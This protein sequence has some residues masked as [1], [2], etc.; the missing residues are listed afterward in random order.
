M[1]ANSLNPKLKIF[2]ALSDSE[3]VAR[4]LQGDHPLFELL[5]R[6]YNRRLFRYSRGVLNDDALAQD[7]VQE[8][9]LN[10][11]KY[12]H[13]FRGPHGFG[14]WLMRITANSAIRIGRKES[15]IKL[16]GSPV[17]PDELSAD[18]SAEPETL[19]IQAE[20]VRSLE[21]AVDRLPRDYRV[22]F[23]L[24]ELEGMSIEETSRTLGVKPA[25]VKSR[26]HRAKSILRKRFKYRLDEFR[27]LAYAFDG[28]RCDS[29]VQQVYLKLTIQFNEEET[30]D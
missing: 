29:I 14:A 20:A 23:I 8:A 15:G 28:V 12:L 18:G 9:Y 30:H 24:R 6:R 3:V 21:N 22:I 11:F 19:T 26:L 25:T 16:V 5:M 17:D 7:A 4:V 13:Q 1:A 2:E 10:A 27:S